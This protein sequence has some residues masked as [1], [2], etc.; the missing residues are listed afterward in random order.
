[1]SMGPE[2]KFDYSD[3]RTKQSFKD[4]TDINKLLV[5]AQKTGTISHLAKFEAVYGDFD[6]FDFTEAQ[7]TIA[8]ANSIFEEL[9]SEL[10][11]EFGQSPKKFFEFANDPEN[12]GKLEKLLPGLAEPGRQMISLKPGQEEPPAGLPTEELSPAVEKIA[13]KAAPETTTDA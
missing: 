5:R 4:Q 13:P 6:S 12:V 11:S 1:M 7:N 8:R 2:R 3:G 10:R 9:P